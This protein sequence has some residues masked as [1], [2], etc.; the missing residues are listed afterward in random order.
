MAAETIAIVGETGSGKT[1]SLRNLNPKETFIVSVTGKPLSFRGWK[2]KYKALHKNQDGKW[3][4][5]YY[6]S[7]N[8][9]S[10]IKILTIVNKLM[11][12]IRQVIVDD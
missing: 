2:S 4:G 5:N 9:D 3:E 7:S 8:T 10:I 1:T 11:P 12:H 6:T